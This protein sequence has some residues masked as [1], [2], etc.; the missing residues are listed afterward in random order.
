MVEINKNGANNISMNTM[1][2]ENQIISITIIIIVILKK[3]YFLHHYVKKLKALSRDER[4][5]KTTKEEETLTNI[6]RT[7]IIEILLLD[8]Q[9]RLMLHLASLSSSSCKP[10]E[11][12]A[13][14]DFF[15]Q[16][17]RVLNQLLQTVIMIEVEQSRNDTSLFRSNSVG[18]KFLS[19]F[20]LSVGRTY[21]FDILSPA[22]EKVLAVNR[23]LEVNPARM[24]N[25]TQL[26]AME[27]LEND[28]GNIEALQKLMDV[29][30]SVDTVEKNRK[31]LLTLVDDDF[32]AS[33]FENKLEMPHVLRRTYTFLRECVRQRYPKSANMALGGFLFLRFFCPVIVAPH[34]L[35]KQ[36]ANNIGKYGNA[37]VIEGS[38]MNEN[39]SSSLSSKDGKIRPKRNAHMRGSIPILPGQLSKIQQRNLTLIAKILQKIASDSDVFKEKYMTFCNPCIIKRRKQSYEWYGELC[40]DGIGNMNIKDGGIKKGRPSMNILPEADDVEGDVQIEGEDVDKNKDTKQKKK[41]EVEEF[42]ESIKEIEKEINNNTKEEEEGTNKLK[43]VEE[44]DSDDEDIIE[45]EDFNSLNTIIVLLARNADSLMNRFDKSVRRG[46]ILDIARESSDGLD[47]KSRGDENN[48]SSCV[49]S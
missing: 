49:V 47:E 42:G 18:V 8:P 36:K 22:I 13:L 34:L 16:H 2:K 45:I 38:T 46:S 25:E 5:E 15:K 33:I 19:A 7:K 3:E 27:I 23:S 39:N 28:E 37:I 30:M 48:N 10:N 29:D 14:I 41:E 1:A 12:E 11:M 6:E 4:L 26:K 24:Q 9:Q 35:F 43:K 20:A 17:P 32:L 44:N 21:L 40:Y 31:E